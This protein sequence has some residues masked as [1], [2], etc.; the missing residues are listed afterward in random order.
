[1]KRLIPTVIFSLL[2]LGSLVY[3]A[4]YQ[5]FASFQPALGSWCAVSG[6]N[7][8]NTNKDRI[9]FRLQVSRC[10]FSIPVPIKEIEQTTFNHSI[11]R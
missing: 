1:M 5:R 7:P 6:M 11:S 2:T 10:I 3:G 9:S 8:S 4:F